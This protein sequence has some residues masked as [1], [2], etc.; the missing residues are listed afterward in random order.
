[1]TYARQIQLTALVNHFISLWGVWYLFNGGD[2]S[3]AY[4]S[5][6]MLILVPIFAVNI[7]L[8]RFICHRS[9]KTGP[10]RKKFLT[11][12]SILAA[13]GSP[14]AWSAVH[15]Y[16]HAKSGS[17]D[18]NQSPKNIGVIRAWLT[19][20][21]PISIPSTM[22]RDLVKDKDYK[23]INNHYFKLLY[24]YAFLL[25]LINPLLLVFAFAI[26]AAFCYQILCAFAVIPHNNKFGYKVLPS[27][28]EDDAVNS[29]LASLFSLGEGW[30]NYHHSRPE[31]HRHGHL[32]WELD[33]PAWIIERFFKI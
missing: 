6:V 30:H 10:L 17:V 9:F 27:V 18:D 29:P 26:P 15:R 16:H 25:F 32:P 23:F 13:L 8:H 24:G 22:V 33:P 12:I 5:I 11:Y 4:V 21:S 2:L 3:W 14:M 20:Y 28:G 7:S 1:M 31:D 19:L